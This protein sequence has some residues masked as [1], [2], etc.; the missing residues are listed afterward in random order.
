[1]AGKYSSEAYNYPE[2]TKQAIL[3][4][5]RQVGVAKTP[6]DGIMRRGLMIRHLVMPNDVAG[7]E[8]V[9][10]WIAANLPKDTYVNIMA[11][12]NPVFKAYNYPEIARRITKGICEGG[13]EGTGPGADES[14]YSGVLVVGDVVASD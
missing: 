7:S 3:E 1:M 4:M 6:P 10:E 9:M 2:V 5:H 12:Y 8:K 11:Q 14:G 13:E